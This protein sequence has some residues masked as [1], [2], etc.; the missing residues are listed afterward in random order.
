MPLIIPKGL[1]AKTLLEQEKI[2]IMNEERAS[3][4][5]IRPLKVAIL[6]LMPKKEEAELQL[7]RLLSNT[8]LQVEID[9]IRTESY[10]ST[11]TDIRH[12]ERFYKTFSQI[13]DEKYDAMIVTGAPVETLKFEEI[14]YWEELK[15]ILEYVRK[16]VFSAMFICWASQAALYHYYNIPKHEKTEKIFG[17]FEYSILKNNTLTK[18]FDDVFYT[19]QSRFTFNTEEDVDSVDDL[20]VLASREDTGVHL[21]TTKDYRLVFVAGHWEYDDRTLEG[22]F[23]RD[24]DKG[25]NPKIPSNYYINDDTDAGISVK[26]RG[27]GNLFFY[28]WLNY[29]YQ[30]TPYEINTIEEKIL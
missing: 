2:F 22:E 6:N 20:L 1:P 24:R 14:L 12:L 27:H 23:I 29:V 28:N 25:M 3:T 9:L 16:N 26:W 10:E 13:K 7:L 15:E 18:G 17:V 8:P 19:P 5:D 30:T 11:H 21:A 4:Q